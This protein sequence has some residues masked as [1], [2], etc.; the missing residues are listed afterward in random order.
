MLIRAGRWAWIMHQPRAHTSV[1]DLLLALTPGGDDKL[2]TSHDAGDLET[3]LSLSRQRLR[4][5]LTKG[6]TAGRSTTYCT[7]L[8]GGLV[9]DSEWAAG[10]RPETLHLPDLPEIGSLRNTLTSTTAGHR[11][12]SPNPA[13]SFTVQTDGQRRLHLEYDPT[14]SH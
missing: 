12:H 14:S 8:E 11:Q 4:M 1:E 3:R 7:F 6:H 9:G 10:R 13:Q 2:L 5:M